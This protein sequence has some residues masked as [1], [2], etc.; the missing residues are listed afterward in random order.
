MLLFVA[1]HDTVS[2]Q[3][4][5][6]RVFAFLE[7]PPSSRIAAL[8]GSLIAV[9]DADVAFGLHNPATLNPDMHRSMTFQYHF[10]FDGISDGYAGYATH[11]AKSDITA[12]AGIQFVQYGE[13]TLADETGERL[14]T[15]KANDVAITVGAAKQFGDRMS[16]GAN[17]RFVQSNLESYHSSGLMM[18]LGGIYENP[19][20]RFTLGLSVRNVGAQLTRYS[21]ISE[22]LPVNVML[23]VSKRLEHL[24]FRFSVTAHN[25]QRWDMLYDS[26]LADDETTVIG[27][28]PREQSS[29]SRNLDNVFR[30]LIF[31]GEFL[32]GKKENLHL[33]FGYNHQRRKELSVSNLRSFGGFSFGAGIRIKQFS[34]DYSIATYH[35]AGSTKH[36]GISTNLDRFKKGLIE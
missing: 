17:L 13:F 15:F 29:F 10:L 21:D 33:R 11:F 5:G 12:H 24:P 32:L 3:R 28:A 26:P 18:D 2:G 25:L 20:S 14:G 7:L 6:E 30:H 36:I 34:I 8:G 4:G 31:G 19:D 9:R 23:G 35:S 27:E 16:V 22:D 1:F